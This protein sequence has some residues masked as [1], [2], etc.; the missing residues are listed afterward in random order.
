M[1]NSNGQQAHN[2]YYRGVDKGEAHDYRGCS[3]SYA[4]NTAYSYSTAIAKVIPAKGVKPDKVRTSSP[5]SGITLVSFF[6]MSS[7]TGRHISM[8]SGASPFDVVY[9]PLVRGNR[10]FSPRDLPDLFYEQ[11]EAYSRL[12][13][14][15]EDRITFAQL[16]TCLKRIKE[17][18]CAEWA[19]PLRA[20]K[21]LRKFERMDVSKVS[22]QLKEKRRK[23]A[24]KAA[25]EARAVFSRYV[26]N[27]SGRDYVDF[28]RAL[29]DPAYYNA[30][31]RFTD[32]ERELLRRKVCGCANAW[33]GPAYVWI[34][35]DDLVTSKHVRV[36]VREAAV[37]MKAWAAGHDMRKFR[38]GNYLVI[39]YEGG[40]IQ[41]GCHH[42]PRDNMLALY[43][44]V[45]GKP[46]PKKTEKTENTE[47][48]EAK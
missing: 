47:N 40:T 19:K 38:V 35:G 25:A 44:A 3:L 21:R 39:S 41:I 33:A 22:E 10:D 13:N 37:A 8:I 36:P 30:A 7:T 28:I 12:L 18:A 43:E 11:L 2:F 16:V 9:V 48:T 1:G 14:H 24:A 46:F 42:I 27:R 6:R 5:R 15:R 17:R 34:D 45:I 29:F 31:Y 4:G 32:R 26:K 23:E 20:D